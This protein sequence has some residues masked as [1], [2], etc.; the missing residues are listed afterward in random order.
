MDD[1]KNLIL[2]RTAIFLLKDFNRLLVSWSTHGGH[3][4]RRSFQWTLCRR[5]LRED[6]T[7]LKTTLMGETFLP[8]LRVTLFICPQFLMTLIK[9]SLL[10]GNENLKCSYTTCTCHIFTSIV[11]KR[12]FH[13]DDAF[14]R[15]DLI[16]VFLCVK[17]FNR[18]NCLFFVLLKHSLVTKLKINKRK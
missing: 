12:P 18:G 7:E 8:V 17:I 15:S 3:G 13:I 11:L 5:I 4:K 6:K 10:K 1:G 16:W 9:G 2:L 14:K